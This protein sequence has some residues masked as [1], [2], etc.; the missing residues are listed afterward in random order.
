METIFLI[1]SHIIAGLAGAGLIYYYLQQR[2]IQ[3]LKTHLQHISDPKCLKIL[4]ELLRRFNS[5][6]NRLYHLYIY[7]SSQNS[8]EID[9]VKEM[10]D[11]LIEYY[12]ANEHIY[13]VKE[14]K[15]GLD[16]LSECLIRY[17][18]FQSESSET[19]KKLLFERG[20][21]LLDNTIPKTY[22]K[23]ARHFQ[24]VCGRVA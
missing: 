1:F 13:G 2:F 8:E 10:L 15:S 14:Y 24:S 17:I 16:L 20:M 9:L 4:D 6:R 5:T 22:E 19:R 7:G 11:N 3:N 21:F 12:I 18:Q 23:M